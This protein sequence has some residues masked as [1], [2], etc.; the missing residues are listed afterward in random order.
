MLLL[1]T[2]QLRD[3]FLQVDDAIQLGRDP[4]LET[5]QGVG[6]PDA[7]FLKETIAHGQPFLERGGALGVVTHLLVQAF[8]LR[9][10]VLELD[11]YAVQPL[12]QLR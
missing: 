1:K 8:E 9:R 11:L 10:D 5:E 7:V 6:I 2:H 3:P 12:G 4:G